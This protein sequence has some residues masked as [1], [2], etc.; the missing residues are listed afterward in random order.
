VNGVVPREVRE[1]VAVAGLA[2]S[3]ERWIDRRVTP[4]NARLIADE[5][6]MEIQTFVADGDPERVPEFTFEVNGDDS[7]RVTV[8][9]DRRDA[10]IIEVDRFTLE[11]PL[12]GD[13]LIT[14]HIDRPG[15]VGR[16]GT[17]LGN[18]G[19]NIAGM[20]VGRHK[21]RGEAIMVLNV[22]EPIPEYTMQEIK[23]MDDV[24]DAYV[25]SLPPSLPGPESAVDSEQLFP[26]AAD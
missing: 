10:G 23:V 3:L 8:R 24:H 4:V 26:A 2:E 17:L 7:H 22:D 13:V 12:A 6:G 20:Q 21:P 15:I 25:V 1:H 16:V 9:W 11:R 14:H 5:L 19:I 18:H